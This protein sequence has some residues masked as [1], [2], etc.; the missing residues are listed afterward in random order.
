VIKYVGDDTNVI[1]GTFVKAD[2]YYD[3]NTGLNI[4]RIYVTGVPGT[5]ST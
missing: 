3:A 1:D 4:T 2:W 5:S